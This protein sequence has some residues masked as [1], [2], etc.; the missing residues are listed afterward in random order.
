MGV[1]REGP[2]NAMWIIKAKSRARNIGTREM[3]FV[4][5]FNVEL[6]IVTVFTYNPKLDEHARL[7]KPSVLF[8]DLN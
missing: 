5:L 1:G 2:L 4:E 8:H 7:V 3:V 6:L